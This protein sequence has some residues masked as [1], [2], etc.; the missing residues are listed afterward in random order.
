MRSPWMRRP[1][2]ESANASGTTATSTRSTKRISQSSVCEPGPP[3]SS[4]NML[5]IAANI[6][7]A[8]TTYSVAGPRR[9]SPQGS[10][11]TRYAAPIAP[12]NVSGTITTTHDANVP[13]PNSDANAKAIAAQIVAARVNG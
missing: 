9:Y 13:A 5:R 4:P 8:A 12:S 2:V 10:R 11:A 1:I 3:L 7:S 6:S